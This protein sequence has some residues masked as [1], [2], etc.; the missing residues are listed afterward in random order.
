MQ[1]N[2]RPVQLALSL[3]TRIPG[4]IK[5]AVSPEELGASVSWYSL[6]G[7]LI[8]AVLTIIMLWLNTSAELTALILLVVWI[9]L[10]GGLHIDGLADTADAW[11][12]GMGDRG[13]TLSIL[14]DPHVGV[15][16]V[17]A[18]VILLLAKW[19]CLVALVKAGQWQLLLLAPVIGRSLIQLCFLSMAYV[20]PNGMGANQANHFQANHLMVSFALT[21]CLVFF[22]FGLGALGWLV[23]IGGFFLLFRYAVVKRLGGF[24]GDIAGAVTEMGEV[25]LLLLGTI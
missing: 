8:G 10:S 15:F 5:T 4:G 12:G 19:V 24:T 13:R 23:A 16:G 3:L 1:L 9:A 6:V 20:S 7:L 17:L 2:L 11:I 25:L 22:L 14:K 18:I 21:A